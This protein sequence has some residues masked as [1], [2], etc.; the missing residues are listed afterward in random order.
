MA[1][2]TRIDNFKFDAKQNV[3]TTTTSKPINIVGSR[4]YSVM[5]KVTD[6]GSGA[7]NVSLRYGLDDTIFAIDKDS[8]ITFDFTSSSTHNIIIESDLP[9]YKYFDVMIDVASGSVS[10]ELFV[11]VI[12]GA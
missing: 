8:T 9:H 12:D 2:T 3:T 5:I 11:T 7:G 1:N 10:Y 6:T 4:G